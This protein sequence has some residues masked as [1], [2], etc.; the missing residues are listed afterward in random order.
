M[1]ARTPPTWTRYAYTRRITIAGV[2]ST[3]VGVFVTGHFIRGVLLIRRHDTGWRLRERSDRNCIHTN[4]DCAEHS[5]QTPSLEVCHG[6]F[7]RTESVEVVHPE[8]SGTYSQSTPPPPPGKSKRFLRKIAAPGTPA[9]RFVVNYCRTG[10]YACMPR[11]QF[12]LIA[13]F[14]SVRHRL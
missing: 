10:T 1:R 4:Y 5:C 12:A 3:D 7:H 13:R 14:V 11:G 6:L 9:R 8:S 2:A